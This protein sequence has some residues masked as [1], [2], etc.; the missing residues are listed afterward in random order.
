MQGHL[1]EELLVLGGIHVR[2]AAAQHRDGP[3]VR[4]KRPTVGR[5]VDPACAARDDGESR[6]REQPAESL[7]LLKA[8]GG[9]P[10]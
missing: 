9:A 1:G 7:G 5:G 2:K 6:A 3:P 4:A 8:V 10:A